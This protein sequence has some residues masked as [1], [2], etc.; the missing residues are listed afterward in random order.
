MATANTLAAI[1]GGADTVD[2]TVNGLGERAGNA[3]LDEVVMACQVCLNLDTGIDTR[4]LIELAV[5]V[6]TASGRMLPTNKP[7]TG[8]SVF[9]HESGIHVH[10]MIRDRSSYE[11]FDPSSIGRMNSEFIL[12][13]HSGRAALRHILSRQGLF[14]DDSQEETLLEL[15]RKAAMLRKSPVSDEQLRELYQKIA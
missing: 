8:R 9:M 11:P 13:K 7:V 6:E 4:R 1:Q 5:L 3:P 2:V 15:I 10:A 14:V 12:G